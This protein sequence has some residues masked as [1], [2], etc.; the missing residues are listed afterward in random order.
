MAMSC[1]EEAPF[2]LKP[3]K[4]NWY[5]D[6]EAWSTTKLQE[7][8]EHVQYLTMW[9]ILAAYDHNYSESKISL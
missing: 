8:P 6:E 7:K 1:H 4:N 5:C 3:V 2:P 9:N